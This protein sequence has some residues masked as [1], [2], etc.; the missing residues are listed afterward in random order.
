M[1]LA[2]AI[3]DGAIVAGLLFAAYLFVVIAP[4]ARTFGFDALAYWVNPIT[5]PYRLQTGGLGAF[6]YSPVAARLFA[7][8][9]LLSWPA[10]LWVWTGVLLGTALWLGGRRRWLW[11]LAFPPVALE[12]YHGNI[13]LL[14][15]AAIALGFRYPAAWAFVLLTKVTPGVG[16]LW[17][18][19]RREWR[20]LGIAL[21]ATAALV[22]VSV[23]VDPGLWRQW[24]ERELVHSLNVGPDQPYIAIPLLLRL[25]LAAALV[26]WGAR[27][28]RA[29]T[30]PVAAAFS[31][32]VL[33]FTAFA[34]LAALPAIARPQLRPATAGH[35]SN[36]AGTPTPTPTPPSPALAPIA[37]A[38]P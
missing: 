30:V 12:L 28:D 24:I 26:V 6:L 34:I 13:H 7:P 29:W 31:T 17:F 22:A 10:F 35:E 19:V 37:K 15:A 14:I 33:W 9:A 5:D 2:R 36:L 1:A 3:R 23:V 25:P 38:A 32:P 21:G 18:L 20:S 8:A 16:L 27:T 11:V 4:S